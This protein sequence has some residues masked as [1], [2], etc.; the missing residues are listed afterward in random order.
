M[1]D[2]ELKEGGSNVYV[3]KQNKEEY[4]ELYVDYI[5]TKSCAD[6]IRSF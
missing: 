5:F 1:I 6:Q 4:V 3:T 2:I